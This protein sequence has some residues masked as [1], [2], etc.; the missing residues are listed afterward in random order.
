MRQ[1][2]ASHSLTPSQASSTTT[3]STA[4][5]VAAEIAMTAPAVLVIRFVSPVAPFVLTVEARSVSFREEEV[6]HTLSAITAARQF[7][8]QMNVPMKFLVRTVQNGKIKYKG[9]TT[10]KNFTPEMIEKAKAVNSAEELF[11]LAKENGS[12]LNLLENPNEREF[13]RNCNKT[14]S[15]F[16]RRLPCAKISFQGRR[17]PYA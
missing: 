4:L 5:Q 17:L 14:P 11:A 9:E 2:P 6:T 7:V 8:V 3:L 13:Y 16:L 12:Y 15:L 1:R 10:M